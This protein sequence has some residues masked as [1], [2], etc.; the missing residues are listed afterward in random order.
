MWHVLRSRGQNE[1]EMSRCVCV[2]VDGWGEFFGGDGVFSGG[3]ELYAL[4]YD[5]RDIRTVHL[6]CYCWAISL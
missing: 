4:D 2:S 5:M 6:G 1:G 3:E